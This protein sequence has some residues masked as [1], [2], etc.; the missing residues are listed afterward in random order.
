[1]KTTR[2][3]KVLITISQAEKALWVRAAN[4]QRL[5]DFIKDTVNKSDDVAVLKA[6]Q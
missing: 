3:G 2:S 4:G 6:N 5:E 1:M